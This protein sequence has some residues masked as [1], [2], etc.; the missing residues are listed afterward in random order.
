MVYHLTWYK[1]VVNPV[2]AF[3]KSLEIELQSAVCISP[4]ILGSPRANAHL[5][6][7][8]SQRFLKS[9]PQVDRCTIKCL[10]F[11]KTSNCAAEN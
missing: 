5:P 2:K 10:K 1:E 4:V 6:V 8:T 11:G 7:W 9:S 3:T